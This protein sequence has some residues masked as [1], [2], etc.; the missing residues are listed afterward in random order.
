M[1]LWSRLPASRAVRIP[2]A[3]ALATVFLGIPAFAWFGSGKEMNLSVPDSPRKATAIDDKVLTVIQAT[4]EGKISIGDE[5][6]EIFVVFSHPMVPLATLDDA[7]KGVFTIS[8]A[9]KG[10]YR[11][12]GSRIS[13]FVPE[14]DWKQGVEYTVKIPAGIAA[15]TGQ[16]LSAA[17]TFTF[18]F[19]VPPLEVREVYPQQ[20]DKIRYSEQFRIAF[21]FPVSAAALKSKLRLRVNGAAKPFALR[22]SEERDWRGR[23]LKRD[24]KVWQVVPDAPFPKAGKVILSV[25]KGLKADGILT[26]LQ[27]ESE[28]AYETFG[29]LT[30]EFK[31]PGSSWRER[32]EAGFYFSNPVNAR[33]AAQAIRFS[34]G[35]KAIALPYGETRRIDLTSFNLEPGE[36]YKVTL[37]PFADVFGNRLKAGGTFEIT[38]PDREQFFERIE[39]GSVIEAAM[40][41]NYPLTVSNLDSLTAEIA[42]FQVSDVLSFAADANAYSLRG[43]L[44]NKAAEKSVSFRTNIRR[45]GIGRA[46]FDLSPY[47]KQNRGWLLARIVD[48]RD[49]TNRR[50]TVTEAIQSTDLA[51]TA[52]PALGGSHT[53]VHSLTGGAPIAGAKVTRYTR[54]SRDGSCTTNA[55]GYCLIV[56][57]EPG[58]ENAVITYIAEKDNDKTFVSSREHRLSVNPGGGY[59][60]HDT[61]RADIKGVIVFDRKLH[62]PGDT[63]YFK[64]VLTEKQGDQLLQLKKKSVDVEIS[65]AS[66][67]TIL[68]STYKTSQQGGITG[69][70]SIPKDAPLGHYTVALKPD[71]Y[72]NKSV[73]DTFQV[74]EFRPVTFSVNT[75]GLRDAVAGQ[76]LDARIEASY[77]FGAPMQNARFDLN[78][79]RQKFNQSFDN[80]PEFNFGDQRYSYFGETEE[81]DTGF[82]TGE[83][84][85]LGPNGKYDVKL[86]LTPLLFSETIDLPA[87]QKIQLASTYNLTV[88][89]TVKDVDDKSVNNQQT[90]RVFA[91]RSAVGIRA[92]Q[93]YGKTG[94]EMPFEIVAVKNDGSDTGI[95]P[96]EVRFVHVTW[97]SVRTQGADDSLQTRNNAVRT[98]ASV[99]TVAAGSKPQ[100]ISFRPEKGGEYY[101]L[102][103]PEGE[104]AFA[105]TSFYVSGDSEGFY[106]RDDDSVT[107]IADKARYKP[108]DTANIV[109]QSP[110]RT[111]RVILS[112]EREKIYWQKQVEITDYAVPVAVPIKEEFLPNVYLTAL[113]LKPREKLSKRTL[114]ED[115]GAPAFKVGSI[116]LPVDA[117]SRRARFELAYDRTQYGPGD[118]VHISIATEPGAEIAL[119]VA[120]RAVLDLVNY[121]FPDPVKNFFHDWPLAIELFENRHAIIHQY[122]FSA[123]GTNPGGGPGEYAEGMGPGGF[124]LDSESGTRKNFRYTAFWKGDIVADKTGKAEVKFN[125]PDNLST[126]RIMALTA[127]DG[128]YAEYEKEFR[129]QKALVVQPLVPR[130][131]R[132][133]DELG[134][135]AVVINQTGQDGDF[136]VNLAADLLAA[137]DNKQLHIKA[138]EA[139]EV[140]F[141][142]RIH[143]EKYAA[144]LKAHREKPAEVKTEQ[145]SEHAIQVTGYVTA[146]AL[147]ADELVR[148]G[149]KKDDLTDRVK[150]EFPVLESPAA[151]AFAIAGFTDS[152]AEEAVK[153][154]APADTLGNLGSFEMSVASTA[155]VGLE[156]AFRFYGSNPYF[157]LEQRA[158]AF[159]L[160]ITS[161]ELLQSFAIRPSAAEDYDFGRIEQLFLGELSQ[162]VNTDGGLL[163]WKPNPRYPEKSNPYLTAYVLTILQQA[164]KKKF[165]AD[166]KIRA[167]MVKFLE[168][169][170]KQEVKG[171]ASWALESYALINLALAREGAYKKDLAKFLLKNEALLSVRAK[172]RLALAIAHKEKL[173]SYKDDADVRRLVE[174]FRSRLEVTTTSAMIRE[175]ANAEMTEAYYSPTSA[176][177]LVLQVMIDLDRDNPL[178]PQI[179]NHLLRN[180]NSY[181]THSVGL[182]AASLDSYRAAYEASGS[183]FDFMA[184]ISLAGNSVFSQKLNSHRLERFTR[185]LTLP[186]LRRLGKTGVVQPFVISKSGE[187]GRLYYTARLNYATSRLAEQPRDEG[188]EMHRNLFA[189]EKVNGRQ[190]ARKVRGDRLKR[191]ELY[192]Q[193]L[194]LTTTKP[195]F[196]V[197]LVDPLASQTEIMNAAF[198]TERAAATNVAEPADGAENSNA[199]HASEE[200]YYFGTE[201]TRTEYRHDKVVMF[202]DYLPPGYHEYRYFVRPLV[203]GR[204]VHPAGQAKLMYEPEV[205]GRSASQFVVVE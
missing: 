151:E 79:S 98:L 22:A 203:R 188:I 43:F 180:R 205:F 176:L 42:E 163:T 50:S 122:D 47:L 190:M 175:I 46:A 148:K 8:P 150:V 142:S 54:K 199:G 24:G 69:E 33:T 159:Q 119:S 92:Q 61:S 125:L 10:R 130:F 118:S 112:I 127:A 108:G 200:S 182:T 104:A 140:S 103:R 170:L 191:G 184:E 183:P 86:V 70:V 81:Q 9:I 71:G 7:T 77:L 174:F 169:Y 13:A 157:C 141:R 154:P 168:D 67:K 194:M 145:A 198:A 73:Q 74:E 91:G 138:G 155:L 88:D 97:K 85:R 131:I 29:D 96:V 162:F 38:M 144:L 136:A 60:A 129:V 124:A 1:L 90:T 160:A 189:I 84:G 116:N 19:E 166:R 57:A 173:T 87:Q 167:G 139:V 20:Y 80:Y 117:S 179:V 62:T 109:V 11:W 3:L 25:E 137:G 195:Y 56:E 89:A 110:V 78:I 133:G 178:I 121:R 105:R 177:A 39:A 59:F 76:T 153:I 171:S 202:F 111:G 64:A 27:Q 146:R 17:K 18:R 152:R 6:K 26:E 197:V 193:K 156:N 161:G 36:S 45:N 49:T 115:L 185:S 37:A 35:R 165:G 58:D 55:E 120:D 187:K 100:V 83:S 149:F 2:V 41:Q 95:V 123:K 31:E 186:E 48:P 32:Y 51:L 164:E 28:R 147:A 40:A 204:S 132:P 196:N 52:R 14:E 158:S 134:L 68:N 63:V 16:K 101:I 53:W 4:P 126:F 128:K 99:Q 66:G 72:T 94:S 12:Y 143:L 75:S 65:D 107:L 21:N 15:V 82:F 102:A 192:L 181:D 44:E 106:L 23:K 34:P 135:G 93:R 172:A 201:P 114:Y 5:R 113:I 30:F